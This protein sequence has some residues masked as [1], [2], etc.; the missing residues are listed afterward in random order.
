MNEFI[1]KHQDCILGT[2][3]DFDRIQFRV[4][5]RFL[6][7]PKLMM[8]WLIRQHQDFSSNCRQYLLKKQDVH[9]L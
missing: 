5:F 1:S 3:V 9:R 7:V 2:L 4:T 6:A 8:S